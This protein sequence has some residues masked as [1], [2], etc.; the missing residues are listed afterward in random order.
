M[1]A[2]LKIRCKDLGV[3]HP[4][5]VSGNSLN[6]LVDCIKQQ[7][8]DELG[9]SPETVSS[10]QVGDIVRSALIQTCRPASTRSIS[11]AALAA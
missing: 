9:M 8:A 7:L 3:N 6:D 1:N 5:F 11:L 4:G 10:Q 2:P